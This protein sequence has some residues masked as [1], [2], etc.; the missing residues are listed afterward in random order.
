V[1]LCRTIIS[2]ADRRP[3][4][5]WKVYSKRHKPSGFLFLIKF[6]ATLQSSSG[7]GITKPNRKLIHKQCLGNSKFEMPPI[8]H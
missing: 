6:R 7:Q 4:D 1:I 5:S 8:Y 2:P 3:T